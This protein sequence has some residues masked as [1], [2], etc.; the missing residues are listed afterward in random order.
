MSRSAALAALIAYN[1]RNETT[2][3]IDGRIADLIAELADLAGDPEAVIE[4]AREKAAGRRRYYRNGATERQATASDLMKHYVAENH[5]ASKAANYAAGAIS[6][7]I[8]ARNE[9]SRL[10]NQEKW[11]A[12]LEERRTITRRLIA[13]CGAFDAARAA[14][15][16]AHGVDADATA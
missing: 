5:R 8:K 7:A 16:A 11:D 2:E 12:L 15:F 14:W 3:D 13:A 10:R 1:D 6:R 4:A 9:A